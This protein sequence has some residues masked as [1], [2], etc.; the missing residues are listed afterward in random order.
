M[1]REE[2]MDRRTFVKTGVSA[3]L[4]PALGKADIT[5]AGFARVRPGDP[6][7]PSETRWRS[8]AEAIGGRLE[9]LVDP[10]DVCRSDPTGEG[11]T[12]LFRALDNPYATSDSPAL[13]QSTGWLG[14]WS[15]AASA[16]AV[17]AHTTADVVAAV[18]FA[19]ENRLRLVVRGGGHSYHGSSNAPDSLLIWMREMNA[20]TLHEGFLPLGCDGTVAS[21]P[22]VTLGTGVRWLQAYEAVST[23]GGRYV[24]GGGCATVG[25]AGFIQGGGFGSFSKAFGIGA[26]SLLEAEIVTADGGVLTVNACNHPEL[27]WAIKGGGGGSFGVVTRLTLR[28]HALPDTMGAVFGVVRA[29]SDSAFRDLIGRVMRFYA[30]KLFNPT[31]GEQLRFRPDNTLHVQMLFQGI[32]KDSAADL[33]QS[34]LASLPV[35]DFQVTTPFA[36]FAAPGRRFWDAAWLATNAPDLVAHDDRPG[37]PAGNIYYAGDGGEAGRF[38]HAYQS[39]WMPAALLSP[40]GIG[41][42]ADALFA[43]SRAASVSLHFNKGQA[44]AA[45]DAIAA[46][47]DTAMN[48]D[49]LD[50]FALAIIASGE[51]PAFPGLPGHEPDVAAG[52]AAA[53][54]VAAAFAELAKLAPGA[55]SYLNEADYFMANWQHAFWGENYLRLA[56][57]KARYDPEGLFFAHHGVGS[58]AWSSDGFTRLG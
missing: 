29:S 44:G 49:V 16:F 26:A 55:G 6:D 2:L 34:F 53:H 24:Q 17:R 50:A 48:P 35:G 7:W 28:T 3:S 31:W 57:A 30:E 47:R 54:A 20:I 22:A 42:L 4:L 14:A 21:Q 41:Q 8:L 36:T 45:A 43:A 37:A 18:N 58:E 11:C 46:A 1:L 9:R 19:R 25:V 38:W 39:I 27:F 23:R 15:M 40:D 56:A 51:P 13:T 32:D 33:W 10:I 12:A 5:P 52:E